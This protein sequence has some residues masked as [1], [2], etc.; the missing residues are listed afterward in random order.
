M[1][2][3]ITATSTP[4]GL[5]QLDAVTV[6]HVEALL[7]LAARTEPQAAVGQHA[8]DVEHQQ[9]EPAREG[10][11]QARAGARPSDHSGAQQVVDVQRADQTAAPR[12]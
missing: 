1:R 12:R 7:H 8:V 3:E 4:D 6:A 5:Q 11:R 2:P 9:R 10:G